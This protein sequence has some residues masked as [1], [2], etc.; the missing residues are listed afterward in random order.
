MRAKDSDEAELGLLEWCWASGTL[1]PA[2]TWSWE[3]FEGPGFG[4][5]RIGTSEELGRGEGECDGVQREI[6][7]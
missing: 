1:Q 7:P 3:F 2:G 4:Q 5:S 6:T